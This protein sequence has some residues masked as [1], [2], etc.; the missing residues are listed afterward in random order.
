[1]AHIKTKMMYASTKDFFKGFLEGTGAEL[2]VGDGG[3]W[4]WEDVGGH[5]CGAE[6]GPSKQAVLR[7]RGD[8][9]QLRAPRG[10]APAPNTPNP[11]P[12]PIPTRLNPPGQ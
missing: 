1:M 5:V 12:A 9:R 11:T 6:R 4:V 2:Q 8:G 10:A 3:R 7:S